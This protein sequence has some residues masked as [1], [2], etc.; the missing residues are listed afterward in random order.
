MELKEIIESAWN[1]RS[2]LTKRDTEV[3]IRTVIEGLDKG[4]RRVAEPKADGTWQVNEW[5]KK[6]AS[7]KT[8]RH[9]S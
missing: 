9:C 6:A 5:I 3:A 1:D 7:S 2:L 8:Q 4:L